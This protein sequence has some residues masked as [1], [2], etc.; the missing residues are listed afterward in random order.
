MFIDLH[1]RGLG[2]DMNQSHLFEKI[3]DRILTDV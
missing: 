3:T 2:E 1:R